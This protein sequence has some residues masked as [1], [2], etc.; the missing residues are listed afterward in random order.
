M[1]VPG[2]TI[3]DLFHLLVAC[4][5]VTGAVGLLAFWIPVGGRKGGKL[6]RSGGTLFTAMMLVT[7]TFAVGMSLC[8]LAAPNATHPHLAH[9]PDLGSAAMLRAIFGWMMLY[10]AILTVNLAWY[11]WLCVRHKRAREKGRSW[12]N[13]GL[14]ALL[15]VAAA[16]CAWQAFLVGVPLLG[17]M[18]IVGFATVATNLYYLYKPAPD[19]IE[20]LAEHIKAL[21]G[22]GIS[23]YT[24]FFAF[25]AV[26]LLP[27]AALTPALWATPLTIGLGLIL[28]HRRAIYRRALHTS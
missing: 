27:E 24:A 9:H 17:L 23:V 13:L 20:W 1:S 7:G 10:L 18:S 26:R 22:A 12:H 15:L 5:I 3:P 28:Y 8:T 25:G 4:H 11:G 6:H 16:N 14:Q 21:I 2:F 19:P